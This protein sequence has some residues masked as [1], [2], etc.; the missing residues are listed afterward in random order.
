MKGYFKMTDAEFIIWLL[1]M[2]SFVV[3][4]IKAFFRFLFKSIVGNQQDTTDTTV[5]VKEEGRYE[6][7]HHSQLY[8]PGDKKYSEIVKRSNNAKPI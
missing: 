5:R 7:K 1:F 3:L 2:F 4:P 8:R 6:K